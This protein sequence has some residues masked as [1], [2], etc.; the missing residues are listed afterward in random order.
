[1]RRPITLSRRCRARTFHRG[2]VES[3]PVSG[4]QLHSEQP[5]ASVTHTEC[6]VGKQK[7]T[8]CPHGGLDA[9]AEGA[10]PLPKGEID[11]ACEAPM[12]LGEQV[13]SPQVW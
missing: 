10:E 1:M 2:V 3:T 8:N 12:E 7:T 5:L 11:E 6:V 9:C 13:P 4:V